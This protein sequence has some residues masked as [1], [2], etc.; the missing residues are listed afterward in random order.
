MMLCAV[1]AVAIAVAP[2]IFIHVPLVTRI[3]RVGI[4]VAALLIRS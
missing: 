4:S 3:V 1:S 2:S